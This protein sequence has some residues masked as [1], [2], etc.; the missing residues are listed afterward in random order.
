LLERKLQPE[1]VRLHARTIASRLS[2]VMRIPENGER[3]ET[4][5]HKQACDNYYDRNQEAFQ[6]RR[7]C[8]E[9]GHTAPHLEVS[10]AEFKVRGT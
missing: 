1:F 4:H 2:G 5:R 3:A 6:A 9:E 7:I 8:E 10:S